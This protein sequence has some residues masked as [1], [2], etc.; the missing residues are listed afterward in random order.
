[1]TIFRKGL[2]LIAVPLLCQLA[3]VVVLVRVLGDSNE[4]ER[5][6]LHSKTVLQQADDA[7]TAMVLIQGEARGFVIA[8]EPQFAIR[9]DQ[10][11]TAMR[12]RL[13]ELSTFVSDNPVQLNRVRE[14][15]SRA[16]VYAAWQTDQKNLI[17]HDQQE[18]AM[19]AVTSLRGSELLSYVRD[20][21]DAFLAE[22]T[23]LDQQR[24]AGLGQARSAQQ[25]TVILGTLAAAAVTIAAA[26]VFSRSVSFRLAV[27]T[28][29]ATRL[30]DEQPLQ[31]P[32]AGADEIAQLDAVLHQSADRLA[33]AKAAET[34]LR[35]ELERRASE[36]VL[37][38]ETLRQQTQENEMFVY[39][40]SHDLRSPLVNLQG[41]SRELGHACGD[42][43]QA[44]SDERVPEDLRKRAHEVFELDIAESL[45]FIQS[46]VSRSS[47]IIDSLLRLS[48]AGRVEYRWQTV[49]TATI[50][51]RVVDAMQSTIVDR[52][53][54][55][56][57]NSMPPAYGDPTAIEQILGNLVGNAVNYLS[58]DRPGVVEIG[59]LNDGKADEQGLRTYYVRDNGLGIPDAY[60][61][62]VFV[63]FQRL[64]GDLAK[65]EG[66]GL[67]LV[68]R[69]VERHGGRVRVESKENVGS[70]FFVS[71]PAEAPKAESPKTESSK[72]E[73]AVG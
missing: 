40:V 29:N 35:D 36:L 8:K 6:A 48:R 55:L 19:A 18:Q 47:A 10:A 69:M 37:T 13:A 60:L 4:A 51:S 15:Q 38:N 16:E 22:E 50:A 28:E 32:V 33:K 21:L 58:K 64:H 12:A 59:V 5:L 39:S 2:L 70:T 31:P 7:Y 1:M 41:F 9:F 42:M 23:R 24:T 73:S 46:A 14:M 27:V 68:R 17:L 71:L 25:W 67:A 45:R 26:Y 66:I 62:K 30:A 20:V 11:V 49:D 57:V 52:Q 56:V 53:A 63:A 3:F 61:A 43:K 44:M 34:E 72:A 65:G 54:T